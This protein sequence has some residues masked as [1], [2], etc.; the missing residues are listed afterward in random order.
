MKERDSSGTIGKTD[1]LS[2]YLEKGVPKHQVD[3]E[4]VIALYVRMW[5][6]L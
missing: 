3:A 5:S 4:I 6:T 2:S 1:M